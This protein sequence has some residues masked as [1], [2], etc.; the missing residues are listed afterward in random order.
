MSQV[1]LP[2]SAGMHRMR[3]GGGALRR[4]TFPGGAKERD[5]IFFRMGRP[6]VSGFFNLG[7]AR[8]HPGCPSHFVPLCLCAFVPL[9]GQMETKS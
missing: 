7:E 5:G 8:E 4:L 9:Y 3:T 2:A 1:G 6:S